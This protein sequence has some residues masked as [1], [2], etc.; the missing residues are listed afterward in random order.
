MARFTPVGADILTALA[1]GDELVGCWG[2]V[3]CGK[4]YSIAGLCLVLG[5]TRAALDPETGEPA[6]PLHILVTGRSHGQLRKNLW[7]AFRD[8]VGAAGGRWIAEPEWRRWELPNGGV[9]TFHPYVCHGTGDESSNSLEGMSLHVLIAD[10]TAQLPPSFWDHSLERCRLPSVDVVSGRRY[11]AQVVWLSRPAAADGYIRETR[12]RIAAGTPGRVIIG[13]TRDNVHVDP[14]TYLRKLA[15]GRSKAEFEALTQET[16]GA[17]Y[18]AKGA[19]YGDLVAE[20]WPAG[21]LWTPPADV[22]TYPT[23]LAID[24]GVHTTSCL[25]IQLR[26]LAP[27]H[28]AVCVVDEWHPETATDVQ[29]IVAEARR[30]PWQ[31]AEVII[32]PAAGARQRAAGLTSEV[33]VLRRQPDD[34]PDGLGGGL[35]V[36]VTATLPEKRRSVRGGVMRVMARIRA[37]DGT[38]SLVVDRRLWDSPPHDRGLRHTVQVY[39]WGPDGEPLKGRRGRDADHCADALRYAVACHAWGG[40]P[41]IASARPARLAPPRRPVPTRAK[42]LV[43]SW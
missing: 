23:L 9:I 14:V 39:E 36:P 30:R 19:I 24:S 37:A 3:G 28:A 2:G 17:T 38:R 10:E 40:P 8:V 15:R 22:S 5:M 42:R 25:W 1:D 41:E 20:E 6:G 21:N 35:G 27:G 12:R 34:D 16:P 32:D 26:E 11:P 43:N 18:P 29:A 4:S 13:R 33:D 7:S 31:L